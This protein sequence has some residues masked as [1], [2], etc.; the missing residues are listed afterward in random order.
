MLKMIQKITCFNETNMSLKLI[1]PE[2]N[3]V[4]TIFAVA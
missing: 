4:N 3:D 1:K 2:G